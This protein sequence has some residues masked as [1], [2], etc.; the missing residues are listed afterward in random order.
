[1]SGETLIPMESTPASIAGM[2]LVYTRVSPELSFMSEGSKQLQIGIWYK[3]MESSLDLLR[4][5]P[6]LL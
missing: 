6:G 3:T 5:S 4:S 1:M 2:M